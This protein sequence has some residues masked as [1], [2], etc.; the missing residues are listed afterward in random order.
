MVKHTQYN[1]RNF[2][3][4]IEKSCF[5]CSIKPLIFFLF[6]GTKLTLNKARRKIIALFAYLRPKIYLW[7]TK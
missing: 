1:R 4:L 2:D 6:F 3:F 5:N 7:H